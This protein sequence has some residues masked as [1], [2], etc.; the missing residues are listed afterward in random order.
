MSDAD[1]VD[2]WKNDLLNRKSVADYLSNHLRK[3][4]A[5][6]P[7]E[8]GFVL[9]INAEWGY[10]KTFLLNAW[11]EDLKYQGHPAVYFDAWKNDFTP[12]PLVAFI[13]K[14]DEELEALFKNERAIKK[15]L[16]E[17][18]GALSRFTTP[19]L[20]LAGAIAMKRLLNISL[21]ELE[22]IAKGREPKEILSDEALQDDRD[23]FVNGL[24]DSFAE[25]LKAHK[26]KEH[27]ISA[28]RKKLTKLIEELDKSRK[29]QLPVFF[30]VDELDRCRPNYAIELLEGIKHLFGVPGIY[31]VVGLNSNQLAYSTQAIY[32]PQFDGSRYLKRFFDQEYLL[33]EPDP[34]EYVRALFQN[35]AI[36]EKSYVHGLHRNVY[37]GIDVEAIFI[38][39]AKAFDAGLRDQIRTM[40]LIE[41]AIAG[42]VVNEIHCWFLFALAFIYEKNSQMFE[43]LVSKHEGAVQVLV[44]LIE[45]RVFSIIDPDFNTG[46]SRTVDFIQVLSLYL[47]N[48]RKTKG[49]LG[50]QGEIGFEFPSSLLNELRS[51]EM[52]TS[53]EDAQSLY[54][55]GHYP[56]LIRHA[57][58]FI[59]TQ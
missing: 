6:K 24:P 15:K 30:F 33:P 37:P 27:S 45:P 36:S 13:S 48:Y 41:A 10:G 8:N 5:N 50:G 51:N 2:S 57:G 55:I 47:A 18:I 1:P 14:I 49:Q 3:R 44:R 38:M 22:S 52:I 39:F 46:K 28:F 7:S 53:N 31:F 59:R 11:H 23:A 16:S 26:E 54:S 29:F 4:Y 12:E 56:D 17:A 21:E 20:R 19:A 40:Q 32:G 9:A 42:I 35:A 25:A 34:R 58:G 43:R